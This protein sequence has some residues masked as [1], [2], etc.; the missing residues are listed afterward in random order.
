MTVAIVTCPLAFFLIVDAMTASRHRRPKTPPKE[1]VRALIDALTHDGRGVA[2]VDGKPVFVW[3]ALPGEEVSFTYTAVRRDFAEA[4]VETVHVAAPQR[5]LPPCPSFGTCGGCSFQHVSDQD[6]IQLKEGLLVEQFERTAKIPAFT[7]LPPLTGPS[8]GYRDKARLGIRHVPKKGRV[9]VGFRERASAYIADIERCPVLVPA[10]GTRL[11][12][13]SA[14]IGELGIKDAI[15][16]IE[17]AHGEGRTALIFRILKDLDQEDRIKLMAF[18]AQ[19]GFE[20]YTQ[21]QGPDSV[22]FLGEEQPPLLRYRLDAYGLVFEF[23]PADFTQVNTSINRQM[24]DR[25]LELLDPGPGERVLDLFC[26]LG[27]FTLPLARKADWVV[28]VEGNSESIRRAQHNAILNALDNVEFHVADLSRPLDDFSWAQQRYDKVLLDPSRA[29]AAEVMEWMG[30]WQPRRVVY[31]SCN[32]STLAR[33]AGI[34]VHHLGYR[35]EAAGVMDMF[36]QTAH[37]ESMAVFVR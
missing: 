26:G 32:P 29:G 13:L 11:L 34:L 35:L 27:N 16:Q 10:V 14:L 5:T 33:D 15:P 21:R 37:V 7:H 8:W 28:G 2:R 1:P 23:G 18:G 12:A 22:E 6:Q 17:M 9:L 30:R 20:I 31:V 36:P 19:M 25:A 4:Q 24:V 3:G